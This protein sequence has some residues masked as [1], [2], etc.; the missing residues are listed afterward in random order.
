M[1]QNE[2]KQYPHLKP[3]LED[4][5]I[6]RASEDRDQFVAEVIDHTEARLL[7]E[8]GG[9]IPEVLSK[10]IYSEI[11]RTKEE[12]W[13]V[14]PPQERSYWKGLAKKL[15]RR[16]LDAAEKEKADRAAKKLLRRIVKN[17]AE[18]IVGTFRLGHFRFARRFLTFLF[19]RLL[20]AAVGRSFRSLF[21]SKASLKEKLLVK[22][23]V[24]QV[25]GLYDHGSIV[26]VPTHFSNIDSIMIGYI[27]DAV[28]GLPANSYGAGLNLYNTG[29][30]AYFMNRLGAYRVDRRKSNVIYNRT[31][32]QMAKLSIKRGVP[33]IFFP[34]GT[35]SRSGRLETKL[36]LGLLSSAMEAQREFYQEGKDRKVF[37]VPLIMSYPFV[38][39]A[40]FLVEQHLRRE[41][42]D[43]YIKVEDS[44]HS[45]RSIIKF[46]WGIFN[47]ANRITISLGQPMDVL[48]NR[49]DEAGNS[50]GGTD[51]PVDTREYFQDAEGRVSTDYQRESEY[52]RMLGDRIVE[53]FHRD[54]VVISSH[55]VSH[56][57]FLLLRN[58]FPD[59][60]LYALLRHPA[61]EYVFDQVALLDVV[62]QLRSL[63]LDM[64][65]EDKIK[66]SDSIREDERHVLE[67]GIRSLGNFHIEKALRIDAQGN[68]VSENFSMLYFYHNRLASYQFDKQL[69]M[70]QLSKSL[71]PAAVVA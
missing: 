20:N 25:R 23:Y 21:S 29:Y 35:R 36:K 60:D 53:R 61:D 63:I 69:R 10:T 24:D 51:I 37:I 7:E 41:G 4:W 39:E 56:A 8:F 13:K 31:L 45:L 58:S 48:G 62:G 46:I 67:S 30:T 17:Y 12:P 2:A 1:F 6:Y 3:R 5:A 42:Q 64:E 66:V 47:K 11:Q 26:I 57:A 33:N 70:P 68:I 52:L 50:Y 22:G 27:L 54:N 59:H 49:V 14:D 28:A 18:E 9:V 16:S 32:K 65:K 55:L 34:G 43:R 40:Q 15:A 44:F 38:L 71:A 19:G